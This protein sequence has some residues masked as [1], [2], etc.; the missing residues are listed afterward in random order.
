MPNES[1]THIAGVTLTIGDRIIQRCSLCGTVLCDNLN[2][3][4]PLNKDGSIPVF[5]TWATG[6]LIRVHLGNPTRYELLDDTDK[7]PDDS[8]YSSID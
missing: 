3:S 4:T 5:P 2:I 8:C 6:R 1:I 7:L